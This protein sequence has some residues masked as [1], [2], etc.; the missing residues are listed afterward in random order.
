MT[1]ITPQADDRPVPFLS[2]VTKTGG[3]MAAVLFHNLVYPVSTWGGAWP[4]FFYVFY[5]G[6]FWV[7]TWML[8]AD[9]VLRAAA[10]VTSV[11]AFAAGIISAYAPG[12]IASLA[13]YLTSI[14]HHGVILIVLARYT[15]AKREVMTEVILA[16]TALYLILGSAFAAIYGLIFWVDPAAFTSATG[17]AVGWQQLLYY[18]YVTLTTLGYG[19]VLPVG[20][21]AQSVA[22]FQAIVGTL[23]TVLLLSRLVG[24]HAAK[25]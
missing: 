24:L 8:T 10:T 3:L 19:D 11:A 6:M 13:V 20:H 22:A 21:I 23:Y 9:P 2:E 15:F 4:L 25:S 14:A 7:G 16:A 18:S 12:S 17:G 5:A 1:G